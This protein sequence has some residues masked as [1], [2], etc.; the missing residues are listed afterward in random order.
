MTTSDAPALPAAERNIPIGELMSRVLF[1]LLPPVT[2]I[3]VVLGSIFSGVATP[4]EA[5]ALGAM[6]AMIL[7]LCA[8]RFSL[9]VLKST[10]EATTRDELSE[11]EELGNSALV[12]TA[13]KIGDGRTIAV[14]QIK[15]KTL[16]V[17]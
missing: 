4:T 2:L 3:A 10:L 7:A 14:I 16:E 8:G 6:G 5:G 1:V 13:H 17:T 12:K 11:H 9:A 15:Q